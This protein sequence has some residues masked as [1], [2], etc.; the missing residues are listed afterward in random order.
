MQFIYEPLIVRY[1]EQCLTIGFFFPDRFHR[2]PQLICVTLL[3]E[4]T[5]MRKAIISYRYEMPSNSVSLNEV[6]LQGRFEIVSCVL[7]AADSI[8]RNL[9]N[10]NGDVPISQP[11]IKDQFYGILMRFNH[12]RT[13]FLHLLLV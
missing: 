7:R 3:D 13:R 1:E 12:S 4:L 9:S 2:R 10:V 11:I 6:C 8:N 5:S